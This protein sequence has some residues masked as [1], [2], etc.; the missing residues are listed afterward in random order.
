MV[1]PSSLYYNS[2]VYSKLNSLNKKRLEKCDKFGNGYESFKLV[3]LT[4]QDRNGKGLTQ[5]ELIEK[6]GTNK[7][8]ISKIENRLL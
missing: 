3:F 2:I 6:C 1:L 8:Y 5:E 4:E 7:G